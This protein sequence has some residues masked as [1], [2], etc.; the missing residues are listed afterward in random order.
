MKTHL[1]GVKV[2]V[3]THIKVVKVKT[4]LEGVKVKVKTHIKGEKPP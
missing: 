3:K 4:L 2:N 1:E